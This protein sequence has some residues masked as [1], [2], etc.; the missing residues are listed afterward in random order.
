MS[1]SRHLAEDPQ[2][3]VL[4]VGVAAAAD[5][6]PDQG[7]EREQRHRRDEQAERGE[8]D[9]GRGEGDDHEVGRV[10]LLA[11]RLVA[12]GALERAGE[13]VE[14]DVRRE[15]RGECADDDAR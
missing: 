10:G 11:A 9:A 4:L 3:L 2:A 5:G 14:R 13:D 8:D 6:E 15:R 7:G 12:L 1:G